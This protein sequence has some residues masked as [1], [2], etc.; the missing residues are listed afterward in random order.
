M[1][2]PTAISTPTHRPATADPTH[3][4]IPAIGVNAPV[5]TVGIVERSENGRTVWEW[6][7]ADYAAGFHQSS[8]RPGQLGNTVISGHNNLKGE[9]F[10]D[11]HKLQAGD[12]VYL[13]AGDVSYRY[14]VSVVHRLR[15]KGVSLEEQAENVR[16]IMPTD[17]ERLTLV[18]CW[19]YWTY[20]HRIIVVAY[21]VLEAKGP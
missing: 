10:R 20:T 5:I 9:V 18:S 12:D 21:P 3:I 1:A 11:L 15:E 8:A 13:W 14:H 17:D 6:E 2:T 16:W 19:P 4:T 7:V